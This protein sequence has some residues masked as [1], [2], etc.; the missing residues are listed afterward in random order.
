VDATPILT[1]ARLALRAWR[2]A[3]LDDAR[4]LWSDPQVMALL[5][6]VWSNEAIAARLDREMSSLARLGYQYWHASD[7]EGFVGCCGLKQTDDQG[8]LVVE[9]GFHLLPRAWGRGYATEATRAA[10]GHAFTAADADAVYAGHHPN[11]RASR[12]VLEK[13]GFAQ[14]GERFYV[15]TGLVH[16]WYGVLRRDAG[17]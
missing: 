4:R 9:T 1:T 8:A 10:L 15:P 2:P 14:V 17:R 13:L 5:G 6:G 11:N 7:E 12:R 3:D 16:P